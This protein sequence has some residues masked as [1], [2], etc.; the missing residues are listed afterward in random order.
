EIRIIGSGAIN[1][2][3]TLPVTIKMQPPSFLVAIEAESSPD[4]PHQGWELTENDGAR[5]VRATRNYL[6]APNDS[7]RINYDFLVP[8][9]VEFVYVFAEVDVN[10]SQ[11]N[12]SFWIM[13]NGQDPAQWDYISSRQDGWIRKW[14]YHQPRDKQHLFVVKP[15]K[16][17]LNLLARERGGYINW[18]VI[19][20]DPEFNLDTY[21]VGTGSKSRPGR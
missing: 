8:A 5:C 21:Q 10:R 15:G 13:V 12:D 9:G 20:N 19:T 6:N 18:F 17:S 14:V 2:G 1:R 16:N 7:A 11:E 4:L 3:L